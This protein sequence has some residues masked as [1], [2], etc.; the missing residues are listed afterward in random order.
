MAVPEMQQ[1]TPEE[2]SKRRFALGYTCP[3]TEDFVG[4]SEF[5]GLGTYCAVSQALAFLGLRQ[6]AYPFDWVR[7]P[8]DGIIH[9]FEAEFEDFLTYTHT[10][11][12]DDLTCFAGA[13]WGGSFW[14]H[15][16][17][18]VNIQQD[19][20]RRVER[21]IGFEAV[22]A[23]KQRVFVRLLNSTQELDLV[24]KLKR[25]LQL[26][27]PHAA[28]YLLVIVEMQEKQRAVVL[29]DQ[30]KMAEGLLFYFLTVDDVYN[31]TK[32]SAAE[33]MDARSRAYAKTIA[34]AT[35]LWAGGDA[36]R[37]SLS[38]VPG[39]AEVIASCK[40]WSGGQPSHELY[41]AQYF[42][43]H[44]LALNRKAAITLPKLLHGRHVE[45]YLP[46]DTIPGCLLKVCAF[47]LDLTFRMPNHEVGG[48]LMKCSLLDH[49]LSAIVVA[50]AGTTKWNFSIHG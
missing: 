35:R 43:G 34:F 32:E 3:K 23:C 4:K 19:F 13:R 25:V 28:V 5:V 50:A 47:E 38:I 40:Q 44:R 7:S 17:E 11:E 21:L 18:K 2:G 48:L 36:E 10:F 12:K 42:K 20:S 29:S 22:P 26:C 37:A 16:L 49:A 15:D 41:G 8:L 14:H 31:N 30:V 9:C 45:F 24:L 6:R 39:M 27:Y 1:L 46:D 33:D